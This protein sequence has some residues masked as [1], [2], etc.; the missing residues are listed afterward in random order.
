M[1]SEAAASHE[2]LRSGT[3]WFG[4]MLIGYHLTSIRMAT[5]NKRKVTSM[6]ADGDSETLPHCWWKCNMVQ[7]PRKTVWRLLKKLNIELSSNPAIP[8]LGIQPKVFKAEIWR[9]SFTLIFTAALFVSQNVEATQTTMN[10]WVDKQNVV[11]TSWE[12]VAQLLNRVQLLWPH[13]LE[14]IRLPCPSPT[15]GVCSSSCPLSRR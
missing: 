15:P 1:N 6:G 14:H 10:R 9:E 8:L 3:K 12:I 7:S 11:D 2:P 4:K 13:G 5:I